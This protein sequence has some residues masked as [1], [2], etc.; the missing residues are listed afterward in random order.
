MSSVGSKRVIIQDADGGDATDV[1]VGALKVCGDNSNVP[2]FVV[3][4]TGTEL[5]VNI[6]SLADGTYF[7]TLPYY[8]TEAVNASVSV[9]ATSTLVIENSATTRDVMIV[10]DSDEVI[11]LAFEDAAVMNQGLRL[12]PN[13]GSY[14]QGTVGWTGN[15]FG[16]CA[17]G[18]KNVTTVKVI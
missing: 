10:N 1:I 9:G 11:Y 5:D 14:C 13:G 15:I 4:K 2:I 12:N 7:F 18:G 6:T 16:I 8:R 3:N 17:S